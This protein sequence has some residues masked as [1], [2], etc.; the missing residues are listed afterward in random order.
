MELKEAQTIFTV[1]P[2]GVILGQFTKASSV[3]KKLCIL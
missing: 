2:L 1:V 3:Y